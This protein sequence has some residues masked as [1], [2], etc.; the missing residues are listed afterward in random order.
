MHIDEVAFWQV[1]TLGVLVKLGFLLN[2]R[3]EDIY[4]TQRYSTF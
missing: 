3:K 1:T 2:E 4:F